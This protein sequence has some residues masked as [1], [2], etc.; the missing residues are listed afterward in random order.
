M[1]FFTSTILT[2]LFLMV[3]ELY[4]QSNNRVVAYVNDD[5]I[6]LYEL[7]N[8][9]EERTGKTIEELQESNEQ[10][11]FVLREKVLDMIIVE[12]LE[13]E[14]IKELELTAT[15]EQVDSYIEGIKERNHLTKEDFVAELE[16]EGLSI[17]K[18]RRKLT[19]EMGRRNLVDAEIV[20]K[21]VVSEDKA[22]EYYE[23]H[24]EI[25][26]KPG[27]AHIASIFLVPD[28]TEQPGDLQKKG[29]EILARLKKGEDFAVL[30][31]EFSNG[32][33]AEEGGDLGE[34]TLTDVDPRILEV[35]N[36]LK[37]G[38]T[39][40]LIDMGNRLQIIKL[41]K[42]TDTEWTP[43]EEVKSSITEQLYDKEMEK[44]YDEY[45]SELKETSYIKKVL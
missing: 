16:K 5:L 11:F 33:G 26:R 4:A 8:E 18:F 38:E 31:R 41:I 30:A 34:I 1:R 43:F 39:S 14:K 44:R 13:K 9:I 22:K 6:T 27:K 10:E 7:N 42:K 15:E 37:D 24:K 32:P 25:Y 36:S 21:T 19:D 3:P 20:G 29:K 12:R 40:S 28:S 45:V 17:E 35:I 23:S 2:I